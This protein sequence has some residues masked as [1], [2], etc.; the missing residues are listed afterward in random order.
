MFLN[1]VRKLHVCHTDD[2]TWAY[3]HTNS[4][5]I[6]LYCRS[7][8]VFDNAVRVLQQYACITHHYLA[9][10]YSTIPRINERADSASNLSYFPHSYYIRSRIMESLITSYVVYVLSMDCLRR[11]KAVSILGAQLR[12]PYGPCNYQIIL[13]PS[14][15]AVSNDPLC[16]HCWRRAPPILCTPFSACKR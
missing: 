9:S 2:L 12:T 14:R 6:Q 16:W 7:K 10:T 13:V 11:S 8:L 5:K 15:M 4:S 3:C 1:T